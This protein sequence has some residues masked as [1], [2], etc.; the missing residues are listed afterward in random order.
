MEKGQE[1]GG[2]REFWKPQ[3]GGMWVCEVGYRRGLTTSYTIT[4]LPIQAL[5]TS[6]S[7]SLTSTHGA[8]I[9]SYFSGLLLKFPSRPL[10]S[11]PIDCG[12]LHLEPSTCP[13][14]V[15]LLPSISCLLLQSGTV[16]MW[17]R[18]HPQV[19]L[20]V[21]LCLLPAS[22]PSSTQPLHPSWHSTSRLT[23]SL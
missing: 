21:L 5:L 19:F 23:N 3:E 2:H 12:S 17:P 8:S 1:V 9:S 6:C 22:S 13:R 7:L 10:S 14:Y 15:H 18:T 20:H 16:L 11:P 4:G